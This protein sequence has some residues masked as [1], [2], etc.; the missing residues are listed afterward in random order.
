M[1]LFNRYKEFSA[2]LL[3][4]FITRAGVNV[5]I[6]LAIILF[7]KTKE[8]SDFFQILFLQSA[9]IAFISGSGFARGIKIASQGESLAV[10]FRQ[11]WIFAFVAGMGAM[12][13]VALF[14]PNGY[15]PVSQLDQLLVC[16]LLI[17][18]AICTALSSVLQGLIMIRVGKVRI[19]KIIS[20]SNSLA[21]IL[22]F[23]AS[24]N[25]EII[26]ISFLVL[27]SQIL[28]LLFL[29]ISLDVAKD[30]FF[31]SLKFQV[32]KIEFLPIGPGFA[33]SLFLIL[34]FFA[35]DQWRLEVDDGIVSFAFFV[36]RMSDMVTQIFHFLYSS[37]PRF[38]GIIDGL[39]RSNARFYT[40]VVLFCSIAS[41]PLF[42][43]TENEFSY[44]L[45]TYIVF[46]EAIVLL[47]KLLS[48]FSLIRILY[49]S[50]RNY[51]IATF[52]SSFVVFCW[53]VL[54]EFVTIFDLQILNM[55][56][57][58]SVVSILYVNYKFSKS[59]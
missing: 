49:F 37:T 32:K 22:L 34:I 59:N 44:L 41:A 57:A 26:F 11:H 54:K 33:N 24:L 53:I 6:S 12:I 39:F 9:F 23:S 21:L 50:E 43:D 51:Y 15:L 18:G 45:A 56:L 48:G 36:F 2:W 5:A 4:F 42:V 17:G 46:Y 7:L 3:M 19:F 40:M 14:L 55:L 16:F 35:R 27:M 25:R 29:L 20:I 47:P 31:K 30:V 13:G 52:M 10:A 28:N 1:S 8:A 58:I 38:V